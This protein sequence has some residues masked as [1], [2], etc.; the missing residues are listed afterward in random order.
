MKKILF[1]CAFLMTILFLTGCGANS[2]II[3]N[4]NKI[5]IE[6]LMSESRNEA[7]WKSNYFQKEVEYT[8]IISNIVLG[9]VYGRKIARFPYGKC[10]VNFSSRSED[11][12]NYIRFEDGLELWVKD[13]KE[14]LATLKIGDK[15]KVKSKLGECSEID[16][17]YICM[18]ISAS[19]PGENEEELNE[20]VGKNC[21]YAYGDKCNCIANIYFGNLLKD[22]SVIEKI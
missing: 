15:I 3:V 8:G 19:V 14:L 18:M 10:L 22:E 5:S 12:G 20:L 1:F 16:G 21:T 13:S 17:E 7:N 2:K 11:Y 9:P 4:G 6:D